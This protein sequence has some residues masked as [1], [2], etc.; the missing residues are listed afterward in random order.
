MDSSEV[1]GVGEIETEETFD[2]QKASRWQMISQSVPSFW[3]YVPRSKV[4]ETQELMK[5][6]RLKKILL[7]VWDIDE[8][9]NLIITD[10]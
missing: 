7:R 4:E 1:V 3:L 9:G 2:P 8:K 5:Q 10:M 6:Y